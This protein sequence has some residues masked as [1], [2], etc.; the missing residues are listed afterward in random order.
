MASMRAAAE[1]SYNGKLDRMGLRTQTATTGPK[2]TGHQRSMEDGSDGY[3]SG[4]R[5]AGYETAAANED[6]LE[7]KAPK[8]LRLDRPNF[9]DG[10]RVKKGTTVNVIVAG[11]GGGPGPEAALA[12]MAAP[13]P[14]MPAPMPPPMPPMGGPSPMAGAAPMPRKNGGRVP[15]HMDAG[16]GGGKGRLEKIKRYGDRA[17]PSGKAGTF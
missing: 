16:A 7:A 4:G 13:K 15:V 5:A 2:P 8:K 3:A 1:D 17:K 10:G 11:G 12:A 6:T 9:K 14:P